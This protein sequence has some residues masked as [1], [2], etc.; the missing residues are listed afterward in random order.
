M[1]LRLPFLICLAALAAGWLAGRAWPQPE[2]AFVRSGK[3]KPVPDKSGG[4]AERP[5][6]QVERLLSDE[7][8]EATALL[9]A[10]L[11]DLGAEDALA[12]LESITEREAAG[13]GLRQRAAEALAARLVEASPE[14]ALRGSSHLA[15]ATRSFVSTALG[16]ATA[17]A[18]EETVRR[19]VSPAVKGAPHRDE[20][21]WSGFGSRATPETWALLPRRSR[22]RAFAQQAYAVNLAE[23][24]P[25]AC[26]A[27]A[28]SEPNARIPA[29]AALA[30]K[31][32]QQTL[33]WLAGLGDQRNCARAR[34]KVYEVWAARDPAAVRA[35]LDAET[36]PRAFAAAQKALDAARYRRPSE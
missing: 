22:Q 8:P 26:R 10:K 36:S 12:L 31:D 13:G 34:T 6:Q 15:P 3:P 4:P 29:A 9:A 30:K 23:R 25:A 1:K 11:Q 14:L 16:R 18:D 28:Q 17:V 19:M 21:F 5:K 35:A 7:R 32:P 24:D 2:A 33:T 20:F 27:W